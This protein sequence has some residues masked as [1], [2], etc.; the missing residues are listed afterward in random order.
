MGHSNAHGS[1]SNRTSRC[2]LLRCLVAN[3]YYTWIFVAAGSEGTL[4]VS[5]AWMA[6][7]TRP[8]SVCRTRMQP[9]R[10]LCVCL[11][12]AATHAN[13]VLVPVV[14]CNSRMLFVCLLLAG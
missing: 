12:L 8:F 10:V 14:G 9:M 11:L 5:L 13:A 4:C 2:R 1:H 6:H 3:E 7:R